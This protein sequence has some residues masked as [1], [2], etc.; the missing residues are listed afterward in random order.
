MEIINY[1]FFQWEKSQSIFA[2]EKTK[3]KIKQIGV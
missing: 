1:I 3:F 2:K